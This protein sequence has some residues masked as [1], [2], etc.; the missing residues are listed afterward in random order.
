LV[1]SQG[2]TVKV[3]SKIWGSMDLVL[4][5]GKQHLFYGRCKLRNGL[6][7]NKD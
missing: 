1:I 3:A 4:K 7:K 2:I 6:R 5:D